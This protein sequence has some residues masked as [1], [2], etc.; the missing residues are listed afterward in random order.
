V[1][2]ARLKLGAQAAAVALVAGLLAL[3]VWKVTHGSTRH[4]SVGQRT[5]GFTL[6]RIGAPGRL[7]LASL[8]GKAI[9]LN[10]WASWCI[11]CKAE[12]PQLESAWQRWREHGVVV[13]GVDSQD[14]T[15][16]ARRFMRRHDVTYPVVHDSGTHANEYGLPPYPETF[17]LDRDGRLV[18][19][20]AGQIT[21]EAQLDASIR[22]ALRS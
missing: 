5:P 7:S 22:R 1:I 17:V 8:R 20:I 12:A 21:S 9:V 16:D 4:L 3:L 18:E 19:H 10:F 6:P 13:L 15:G 2:A 14:F 11:P